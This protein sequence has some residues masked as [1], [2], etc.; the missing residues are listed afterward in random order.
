MLTYEA[1]PSPSTVDT[2]KVLRPD[3]LTYFKLPRPCVVE[4]NDKL[5][6]YDIIPSP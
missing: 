1:V 4:V 2:K 5:L 6:T 3:V